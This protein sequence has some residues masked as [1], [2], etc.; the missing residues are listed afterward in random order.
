[1]YLKIFL[2]IG[3]LQIHSVGG[4]ACNYCYLDREIIDFKLHFGYCKFNAKLYKIVV[5][6]F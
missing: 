2:A 4:A 6:D 1:M 5:S 3:T